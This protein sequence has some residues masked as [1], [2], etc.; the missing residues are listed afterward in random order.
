MFY[1]DS[2]LL[3]GFFAEGSSTSTVFIVACLP[4]LRVYVSSETSVEFLCST[5]SVTLVVAM[6]MFFPLFVS[7]DYF[8]GSSSSVLDSDFFYFESLAYLATITF[9]FEDVP[10]GP[11]NLCIISFDRMWSLWLNSPSWWCDLSSKPDG[12]IVTYR[13]FALL[14]YSSIVFLSLLNVLVSVI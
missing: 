7:R 12:E 3:S 5:L 2:P 13:T 6:K 9:F 11:S 1:R 14:Y 10:H 4:V 8:M